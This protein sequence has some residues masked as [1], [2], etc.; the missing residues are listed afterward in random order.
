MRA[1]IQQGSEP[2][3]ARI[4]GIG[5][6]RP[7]MGVGNEEIAGLIDSTDEWI[8]TRSGIRSRRWASADE[9]VLEMAEA[10]ARQALERSGVPAEQIGCV[11]LATIS[12]FRQTPAA[13][14]VLA[15]RIGAV[16]AGSFD[17]SA[18]CAGFCYGLAVAKDFV[19]GG[20]ASTVLVVGVERMTD[21]IDPR[22]RGTAFLFADGAGA[23]VV[24]ASAE[25]GIGPVVWGSDGEQADT[26]TQDRS[27][28]EWRDEL[29]KDPDAP[30]PVLS[31]KGQ[32]VFRWASVSMGAVARR[33]LRTSGL[34]PEDLDV[35]I[36]HQ[37]NDRITDALVR[38]LRLPDSV[39]VA[40]DIVEQ[41]NT[42]AASIPLAMDS[43][44][45]SGRA[46]SGD[47]ALLLGFGA[48]L[49]FAG[50]VVTL[51]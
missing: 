16:N 41:G 23:A 49:S 15:H 13:A 4:L 12:H 39:V 50:Q 38:S 48:G 14:S 8:R 1:S 47:L 5:A 7:R 32:A 19:R 24:G 10:A 31:M 42:S 36:P 34:S 35:F 45:D 11:V 37:A 18:A 20:S 44:L 17:V 9:G 22:D 28:L 43:L 6:Y 40:R 2:R 51:P 30:F 29:D 33:T 26:I 25:P 21:M 46:K 27:W 3:H